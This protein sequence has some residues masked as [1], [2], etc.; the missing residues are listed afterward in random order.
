MKDRSSAVGRATGLAESVAAAVR[1]RQQAREPRVLLYDEKGDPR[2]LPP[3]APGHDAVLAMAE[4]LVE[5]VTEPPRRPPAASA[6][7]ARVAVE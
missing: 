2:L 5:L 1:R 4:L 7:A 3:D 6:G